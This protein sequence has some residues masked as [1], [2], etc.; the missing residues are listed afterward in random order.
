[1]F[2]TTAAQLLRQAGGQRQRLFDQFL[3][4]AD[5]RLHLDGALVRFRERGDLR[6]HRRAD[7]AH[8]I[9]PHA[10]NPLDD[11]VDAAA[12]LGH[13]ADDGDGADPAHVLRRRIVR[14]V[15]LEQQEDQAIRAERAVHRF[16]RNRPV[17]GQR[18]Q[19]QGKRDRAAE[20][21]NWQFRGESWR[22]RLSHR[23]N[24]SLS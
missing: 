19:R 9:G 20:R 18:L 2:I 11:D 3:D 22:G 8:H 17:D 1:M 24:L 21:K 14:I 10:G 13:L 16:N 15:L 23:E 12:R 4:T 6:A 5:V 7:A